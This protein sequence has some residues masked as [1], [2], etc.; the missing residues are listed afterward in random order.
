MYCTHKNIIYC[1]AVFKT[2]SNTPNQILNALKHNFK[3][4]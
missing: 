4:L 3:R 2:P 1:P